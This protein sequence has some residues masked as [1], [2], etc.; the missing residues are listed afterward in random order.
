M[1]AAA[2]ASS[3]NE[4]PVLSPREIRALYYADAHNPHTDLAVHILSDANLAALVERLSAGLS[5]HLQRPVRF[6]PTAP[7]AHS[8]VALVA[9]Q[10]RSPPHHLNTQLYKQN[11]QEA[12]A[13]MRDRDLFMKWFV[14]KDRPR[15]VDPPH[16]TNGRDRWGGLRNAER[17]MTQDPHGQ[18]HVAFRTSQAAIE[19]THHDDRDPAMRTFLG[20]H[21]APAARWS[22]M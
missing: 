22:T 7:F 3:E 10:P 21:F 13:A 16:L 8:V 5:K 6:A 19:D 20:T 2:S 1:Y 15:F 14:F 9:S 18:Q 11:L 12:Y 4:E 17:Y